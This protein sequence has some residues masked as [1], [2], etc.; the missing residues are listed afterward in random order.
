MTVTNGLDLIKVPKLDKDG[1][2]V[3]DLAGNVVLEDVSPYSHGFHF[4]ENDGV[5]IIVHAYNKTSD[6]LSKTWSNGN[7]K[8]DQ[9]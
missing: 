7:L 2:Q 5:A 4:A 1:L 6:D 8:M 9:W 3:K